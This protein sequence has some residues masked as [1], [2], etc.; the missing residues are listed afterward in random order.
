MNKIFTFLF[1][2]LSISIYAQEISVSSFEQLPSDLDAR[3][4]FPVKDQNGDLCALLKIA[5]TETGFVFEGGQLGIM[6]TE[7]K[8]GE[9]W[10][11]IP[12]GSKRMTIKHNQLGNL[13][14]Y[15]FPETIDKATVYLMKL[16]TGKV[17]VVV[18]D[19]VIKTQ[20]LII[21]SNPEGADV[22]IDDQ[23]VGTTPFQRKYEEKDY[24]Y[25]IEKN[26]YHTEAGKIS[27]LG[28]KKILDMNL[29]PK[30]GDI[31]IN[32]APENGMLIYLDEEN[33]GQRTPATLTEVSSGEHKIKIQSEW[34]QPQT[35]L[36]EVKDEQISN[37]DFS[38]EPAFAEI[39]I[40]AK[41]DADI[42]IDGTKKGSGNWNG[43]LLNGIY[44]IK[45]ERDKH[46][47]EEKQ[48][49]IIAGQAENLSFDLKGKKGNVDIITTPMEVKVYLDGTS[50]G[51]SPITISDLLIGEYELKMEKE[52]YGTI[53]KTITI[54]EDEDISIN[55]TLPQ[56]KQI[57]ITSTPTGAELEIDG[58]TIGKT[59]YTGTLSFT[60]HTIML[61]N[62]T[63]IV[64]ESITVTQGGKTS[65]SF[66]VNELADPF[67]GEMVFVKGGT[68]TMGSPKSEVDRAS[69]EIQHQ[70]TLSDFYIGKYEVTFEQYDVFCTST[71]K[72]KPSD[73]GWGRGK[74][75]VINVSW[76]DA[77]AYCEWLSS[78][79]GKTYRLPTEAEW[80]YACRAGTAK[81]FNTGNI[82]TTSQ[83][84]YNGN[85]P[86][87]NNAKGEYREKTMPVG[88]FSPNAWGLYDMHGNVWERCS[89]LY[90][91]YPYRKQTNPKGA[92]KGSYRVRRGGS[93]FNRAQ[94]CR[95]ADRGN[96][97]P[98]DSPY[99]IGFRVVSPQ[100]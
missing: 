97:G 77:T 34:Y 86:Y 17:T 8:T 61:T 41:P 84:N 32:S 81:A 23:L 44:T 51:D 71:G 30:F 93:W 76:N 88:S 13:Y 89:D 2:V 70:V 26:R 53:T 98:D 37:I 6:K 36:I 78:Q 38:M 12:Y 18:E 83:A 5:T 14:N 33:T 96:F 28:D 31:K 99:D 46:Y 20:W 24:N 43:R 48:L 16:T 42:L 72:T 79:T 67:E 82:L 66:D 25:R 15:P 62:N 60:S 59:P 21:K 90:G 1:L 65:W 22:F 10:V 50:K 40:I 29:K 94:D 92:T 73:A 63:K 100:Q 58:Q 3:V 52:G 35:K 74:R 87:N 54:K 45:I 56:G 69:D 9:Y 47:S 91:T 27:I 80:E 57:T 4:N 19:A 75:P 49:K 7:K 55:E 85:Y 68:F 64:N 95:S 39:S 11:Y